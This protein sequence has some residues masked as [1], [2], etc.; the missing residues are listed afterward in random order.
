MPNS[1]VG[2]AV[3]I[4]KQLEDKALNSNDDS[5]IQNISDSSHLQLSIFETTD[6]TAGLL[7]KELLDVDINGM[8]PIDCMM[9]LQ[10]LKKLV[11]EGEG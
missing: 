4:L 5:K 1:I 11:E 9:K 6:E 10:A 2:R 3:E 7:K 8:T